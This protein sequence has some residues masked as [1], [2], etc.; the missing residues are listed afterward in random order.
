MPIKTNMKSLQPRRQVYKKEM[1]LLSKGF[2]A[3]KSWPGGKITVFPWDSE[4]DAFLL[5]QSKTGGKGNLLYGILEK[6]CDM[7][8]ASVDQFVFSEINSILLV[9]RAIQFDGTIEYESVCPYCKTTDREIIQI[10]HELAPI[11]EKA[12][13]YVGHDEIT[14]PDCKD[15]VCIR[16]LLVRDQKKIESRN[17]NAWL[18]YSDRKLQIL[19]SLVSVN[20]GAPDNLEEADQ[21]YDALSPTDARSLEEK[22]VDLSPRL[23]NRL[24]HK[25]KQCAREFFH[26]LLFD[27]EFFRPGSTGQPAPAFEKDVRA[28]V[29]REQRV[30]NRPAAAPRR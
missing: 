1:T 3:P 25:C 30:S 23:D 21:W 18:N 11:G 27:Q 4:V 26:T 15:V 17:D 5:E 9:A 6:V 29:G 24:P 8:G 19:L 7:N 16:P 28:G 2:S 10:P 20:D 12:E 14:L 13:G 22:Q